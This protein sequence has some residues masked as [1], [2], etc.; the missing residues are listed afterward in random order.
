MLDRLYLTFDRLSMEHCVFKVET[1]GDAYMAVTNL[2]EDQSADH[3]LRIAH[4]AIHAMEAAAST[5]I[6]E[7]N[8]TLGCLQIRVG[9][10]S[11]SK[12]E[13]RKPKARGRKPEP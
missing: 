3:A 12:A 1:I 10:H 2:V 9:F 13:S 6:D 7:T 8:P 11:G 5:L 4:F